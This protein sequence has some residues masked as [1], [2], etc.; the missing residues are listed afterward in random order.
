MPRYAWYCTCGAA[1]TGSVSS[2]AAYDAVRAIWDQ[3]HTGLGHEPADRKRAERA[4]NK[5]DREAAERCRKWV[6]ED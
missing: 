1:M 3:V 4:R 5:A 6:G 2:F